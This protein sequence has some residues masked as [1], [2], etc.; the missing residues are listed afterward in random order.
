M[1]KLHIDVEWI[2]NFFS[3]MIANRRLQNQFKYRNFLG[4]ENSIA[5]IDGPYLFFTV[6]TGNV[7]EI[8]VISG[9]CSLKI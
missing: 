4:H 5:H 8:N 9:I 7:R 2:S 6:H 3:K 1:S